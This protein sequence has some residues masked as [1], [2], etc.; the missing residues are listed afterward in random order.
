MSDEEL[1]TLGAEHPTSRWERES[2]TKKRETLKSA[3]VVLA[4]YADTS[5]AGKIRLVLLRN[6]SNLKELIILIVK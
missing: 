4:R 2:L 3:R 5:Q 6:S 1:E